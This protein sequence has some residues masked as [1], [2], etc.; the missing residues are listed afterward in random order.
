MSIQQFKWNVHCR[1]FVFVLAAGLFVGGC[2]NA[3]IFSWAH[4]SGR[5]TSPEALLADG[6]KAESDG[7]YD[8]AIKHYDEILKTEPRNSEALYGKASAELKNAGLNLAEIIP[9]LINQNPSG[10]EDLL[11]NLMQDLGALTNGTAAAVEAL[12]KIADGQGDGT[13]PQDNFDV[14]LNLGIALVVNAAADLL[15]WAKKSGAVQIDQ[16]FNVIVSTANVDSNELKR[17]LTEAKDKI[18]DAVKYLKV[19]G[20]TEVAYITTNFNALIKELNKEIAKF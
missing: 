17:E 20:G 4:R 9:N 3:N 8:D 18:V 5:D 1:L 15:N 7:R 13:I 6:Q 14:N 10:T 19:A 2:E 16:N 12:K 11:G